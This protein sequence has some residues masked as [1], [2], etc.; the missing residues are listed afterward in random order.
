V[1]YAL[2]AASG[3]VAWKHLPGDALVAPPVALG[4]LVACATSDRV[5]AVNAATGQLAWE[6]ALRARPVGEL[7]GALLV[8]HRDGTSSLLD[9]ATGAP[10]R[11]QLPGQAVAS[12]GRL[13]QLRGGAEIVAWK[14]PR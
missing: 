3:T 11:K 1:L 8:R 9:G 12:H 4:E 13:V 5:F 10:R 2:D 6:Q 14:L 7:D